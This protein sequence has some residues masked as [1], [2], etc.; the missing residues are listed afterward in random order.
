MDKIV[1]TAAARGKQIEITPDA[2]DAIVRDGYSV[3]YGARF[4]KRV[5]D[6][7][8]KIPLSQMWSNAERFRVTAPNG[9]ITIEPV[10][11]LA[12]C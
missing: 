3:A 5:I 4:L 12:V 6:D 9:E 2:V 1:A 10:G 11:A 8:I 7:R